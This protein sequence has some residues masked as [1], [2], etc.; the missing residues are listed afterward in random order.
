M[1]EGE[2]TYTDHE[3]SEWLITRVKGPSGRHVWHAH[4]IDPEFKEH[5][6]CRDLLPLLRFLDSLETVDE[7]SEKV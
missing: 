6:T 5:R 7:Q 1:W 2:L 3:G 4:L